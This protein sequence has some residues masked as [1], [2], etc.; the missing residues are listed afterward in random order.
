ME[1]KSDW[2]AED[3]TSKTFEEKANNETFAKP[4][5][6]PSAALCK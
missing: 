5:R 4:M 6:S 1:E 2:G 3:I